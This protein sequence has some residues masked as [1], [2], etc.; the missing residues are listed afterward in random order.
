MDPIS[1]V[2]SA[3]RPGAPPRAA[4]AEDSSSGVLAADFQT[5]LRLLTTQLKNQDP[6]NPLDATSFA[7]QLA[8]FSG[9]EQQI[10]TN[11]LLSRLAGGEGGTG[12]AELA[13]W[14]GREVRAPGPVAFSGTPVE[15]HMPIPEGTAR[16]QLVA[17]DETG[18]EVQRLDLP[19][20]AG[21]VIWEGRDEGGAFLPGSYRLSV[22]VTAADAP[23]GSLAQRIEA[24]AY[25]RVVE[26]RREAGA[27]YLVLQDG[28]LL[29]A[30]SISALREAGPARG[31]T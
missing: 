5:F 9:V 17:Q 6:L 27:A 31:G 14:I 29:P 1:P 2:S 30:A 22:E 3:D 25:G 7:H 18:R 13:A 12:A 15:V 11:R 20:R 24:E 8:T 21:P 16:A 19:A 26:A 10:Q 4:A 28:R 23:P